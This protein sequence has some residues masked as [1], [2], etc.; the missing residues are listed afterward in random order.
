MSDE[1]GNAIDGAME[2]AAADAAAGLSRGHAHAGEACLNCGAV[3]T[4]DFCAECGQS[5]GSIR[6][7]FWTLLAE[8]LETFFSIDGR[9][10]RTLPDLLLRP[11]RMTRAYLDGQRTRFIPPFRLYVFASLVF[12]VLMPLATGQGLG[13]STGGGQTMDEARAQVEKSYAD[14]DLTEAEY[15]EAINGLNEFEEAWRQGIPG[16]LA[17]D[18]TKPDQP[19]PPG[20]P[21][22]AAAEATTGGDWAGFMPQ[23]A[24]DAMRA[25]GDPEATSFAEAMEDP[26][27]MADRT[28]EWIPRLMFV[29]LPVY[30]LLLAATYFWRRQFLFFDH[31]IVS[32]HFH[33]ALFLAMSVGMLAAML[34]G[35]GWVSLALLVF[36]NWYLYRLHRVV[37]Q[38]GRVASVLRTMT[39]DVVYFGFILAG[40]LTAAILGAL[41][42]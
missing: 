14:G 3:L 18:P 5:A 21:D 35:Y 2:H 16:F 20:T 12:F 13:L 38:R 42:I 22:D 40:L 27:R 10:A 29:M 36:S 26:S 8:S 41:S 30:A 28:R 37:Y 25:S 6:Q 1:F 33:S 9:I 4:S 17:P 23:E 31:L 7:P 11:G 15:Q 39:L 24:L 32:L 34:V 19:V